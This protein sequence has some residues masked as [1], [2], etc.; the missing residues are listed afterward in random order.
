MAAAL[1]NV[2]THLHVA[3]LPWCSHQTGAVLLAPVSP[4]ALCPAWLSSQLVANIP[5]VVAGD[6]RRRWLP[7]VTPLLALYPAELALARSGVAC[8]PGW[9]CK[10][11]LPIDSNDSLGRNSTDLGFATFSHPRELG[12]ELPEDKRTDDATH[13]VHRLFFQ[14]GMSRM[15]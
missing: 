2:V 7:C 4:P 9:I 6:T 8:L 12:E 14:T 15:L 10:K 5:T 1:H 3:A 11:Q 13:I